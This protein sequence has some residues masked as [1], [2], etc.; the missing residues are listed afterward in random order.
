MRNSSSVVLDSVW[1]KQ[2]GVI[3]TGGVYR[4]SRHELTRRLSTQSGELAIC[5]S[6]DGGSNS[7]ASTILQAEVQRVA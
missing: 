5:A 7:G 3:R 1:A 4:I 2:L 6:I